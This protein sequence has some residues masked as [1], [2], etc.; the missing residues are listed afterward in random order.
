MCIRDRLTCKRVRLQYTRFSGKEEPVDIRPLSVLVYEHQLYILGL[1][2]TD[3]P[4][5]YRLS[6]IRRVEVSSMSFDYPT[7]GQFDPTQL[8]RDSFGVFVGTDFAVEEISVRL[9]ARWRTYV[10]THCWH[11]SQRNEACEDGVVVNLNVRM[12]PEVERWILGFGEDAEVVGP[13]SLRKKIAERATALA[14]RYR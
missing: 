11:P 7:R 2:E 6:R 8:F 4:H 13:A 10:E 12:C 5:T 1:D 3:R 9:S 14:A